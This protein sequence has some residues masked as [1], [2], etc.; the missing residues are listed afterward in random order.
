MKDSGLG[1][2]I[3]NQY[4]G[5]IGYA[6]DLALVAKSMEEL[7]VKLQNWKQ[8]MEAKGLRVNM[9]KTKVMVKEWVTNRL[10]SCRRLS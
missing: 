8:A 7:T 9:G 3:H 5:L 10:T 1:C 4:Y 2:R 6:D